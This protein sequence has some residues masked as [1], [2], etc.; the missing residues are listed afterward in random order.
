MPA[1][2]NGEQLI[3]NFPG[4][5]LVEYTGNGKLYVGQAGQLVVNVSGGATVKQLHD[6]LLTLPTL[7]SNTV[8][9]LNNIQNW[10]TTIPLGIPTDRTGWSTANVGGSLGGSG[11]KLNDNTG[12]G[13][14]LLWQRSNGNNGNNGGSQSFGVLGWGLKASDVQSVAGSLH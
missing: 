13:S 6:Y 11:V 10:Q 2:Y 12:I 3:V 14:A 1:L 5:S 9:A 8:T 4:V 7:S